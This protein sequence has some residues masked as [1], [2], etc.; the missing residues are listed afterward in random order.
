MMSQSHVQIQQGNGGGGAGG[1]YYRGD[2]NA[3]MNNVVNTGTGINASAGAGGVSL[4]Q[5]QDFV[6]A[7]ISVLEV[8]KDATSVAAEYANDKNTASEV[9]ASLCENR[10]Q[11]LDLLFERYSD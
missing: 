7:L 11:R 10:G 5:Q 3:V 1:F 2:S 4:Q 6:N 9:Q 8:P